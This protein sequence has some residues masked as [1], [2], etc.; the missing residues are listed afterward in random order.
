MRPAPT[1]RVAAAAIGSVTSASLAS[2]QGLVTC[3]YGAE[4]VLGGMSLAARQKVP[5][6]AVT[7][8]ARAQRLPNVE[9]V[10]VRCST[11]ATRTSHGM[12]LLSPITAA[13]LPAYPL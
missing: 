1:S 13:T 8:A 9:P 7:R 2:A 11:K 4:R 10:G 6:S 3:S 12:T 5:A